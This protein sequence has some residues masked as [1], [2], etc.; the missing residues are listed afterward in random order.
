[1]DNKNPRFSF[2]HIVPRSSGHI[3]LPLIYAII[4]A[5][6]LLLAR[7]VPWLTII[8][9]PCF[10]R[11][12]VGLPCPTCGL[13][14]SVFALARLDPVTAIQF[15]P[16]FAITVSVVMIL[17]I[18]SLGLWLINRHCLEWQL[19]AQHWKR[20]RWIIL[21]AIFINWMYLIFFLP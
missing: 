17:A 12:I 14:R 20:L 21:A 18:L 16:L 1:M 7:F 8:F 13:T 11:K 5:L 4:V 15:N 9:P 10:F 2:I 19:T 3:D 6:G